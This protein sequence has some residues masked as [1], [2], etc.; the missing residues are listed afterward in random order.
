MQQVFVQFADRTEAQLVAPTMLVE[1]FAKMM[2]V[3]ALF[4][5]GKLLKNTEVISVVPQDCTLVAVSPVDGAGKD[6]KRKKKA[7]KTPK[8]KPHVQ[9]KHKLSLLKLYKVSGDKVDSLRE[10]CPRCGPAVRMA[11]HAN[12]THCGRCGH[13]GK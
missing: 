1:D 8:R 6:K 9:K 13:A 12:R 5:A 10:Y 7:K 2:N 3:V 4:F 11:K